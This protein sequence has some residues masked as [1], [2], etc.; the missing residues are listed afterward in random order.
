MKPE[1]ISLH[2]WVAEIDYRHDDRT[3]TVVRGL[4]ELSELHDIVEAGPTFY[5]IEAIRVGPPRHSSPL[6]VEE[7]AKL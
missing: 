4:Q 2:R 1:A 3:R 7:A 6:T 5:A